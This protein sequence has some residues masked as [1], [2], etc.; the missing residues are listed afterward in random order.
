MIFIDSVVVP[1][2]VIFYDSDWNPT[3]DQQVGHK[4]IVFHATVRR[5]S[6]IRNAENRNKAPVCRKH[7]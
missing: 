2:Q 6:A 7:R 1:F 4:N 5:L 3:V